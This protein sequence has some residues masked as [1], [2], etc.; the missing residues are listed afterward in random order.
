[1]ATIDLTEADAM[2]E[3][4]NFLMLILGLPASMVVRGQD[5]RVAMPLGNFAVITPM[6]RIRL[7]TNVTS[8]ADPVSS[9]GT[10]NDAAATRYM[11]QVDLYGPAASDNAQILTTLF[12]SDFA[13]TAM[14]PR[15]V[16]L[17]AED[18]RQMV[19]TDAEQQYE[20]RWTIDLALQ[21]TPTVST[22]QDFAGRV[23]I[24]L[25]DVDAVYPP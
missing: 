18:A 10:R 7:D 1:M 13:T 22:G 3:L 12:R 21:M 2:A 20:D 24:G 5:N 15:V 9:L 8:Y 4:G 11:V 17:Y 14:S 6:L 25:V 23:D 19:F 16:P